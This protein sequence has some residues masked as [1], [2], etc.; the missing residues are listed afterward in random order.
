MEHSSLKQYG[1]FLFD[2]YKNH[3]ISQCTFS[4]LL[5]CYI[6][7]AYKSYLANPL[8]NVFNDSLWAIAQALN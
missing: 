5:L 3:F 8:H 2:N 6:I 4:P 7:L 1:K